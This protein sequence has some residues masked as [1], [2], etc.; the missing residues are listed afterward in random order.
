MSRFFIVY[1]LFAICLA[2][3]GC[4]SLIEVDPPIN[5]IIG[6]SIYKTAG[7]ANTVLVGIYSDMSAGT[8][9]GRNSIAVKTGLA[10]DELVSN[11][12][13][14]DILSQYYTNSLTKDDGGTWG[15]FYSYIFRINSLLEGVTGSSQIPTN[16]SNQIIGE[17]L[18]LRAFMYFYIVNLYGDAPII[19]EANAQQNS[20]K[21]RSPVNLVYQQIIS[22][23]EKAKDLLSQDYVGSDLVSKTEERI[24]PNR[25]V[26]L[27]LLARVYLYS[28]K[29]EV[30]EKYS[31]EVIGDPRNQLEEVN[32][33]F[34]SSSHEAIW[35]L[36]S[37]SIGFNT[38]D[39]LTF[40]LAEGNGAP[41]GP[42]SDGRPVYISKEL[43][44]DFQNTDLRR[45]NWIDSVIVNNETYYYPIKYKVWLFGEPITEYLM[46]LRLSEQYLI[47]SE[48]RAMLG[49]INGENSAVADLNIV[50]NRA[51]LNKILNSTQDK[52]QSEIMAERQREL[53]TEMGHRWLDLK[54]TE[55]ID[56]RMSNVALLKGAS[57]SSY[58]ALFPIP[59]TDIQR[60]PSFKGHQNPG[61]PEQ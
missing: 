26:A 24:R 61:Y 11:A 32:S 53:F 17:A 25:N 2:V 6:N 8:F 1:I 20:N 14:Y 15:S 29:W 13:T 39:A 54:R 40:I 50:R 27:S 5:E 60:N 45:R 22:D 31:T 52:I 41:A 49:K 35:Q 47:R 9:A 34:L 58:K 10:G 36:Q 57:W 12:E 44:V 28:K 59:V 38:L 3:P 16:L 30:A 46:V 42:N 4:Q 48:A 7:G 51:G 19:L 56:L 55:V 23:L 21:S 33:A 37:V 43:L 18:F